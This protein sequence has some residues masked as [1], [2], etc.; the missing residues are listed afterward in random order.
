MQT[1]SDADQ[2][3]F[4]VFHLAKMV[5]K[6]EFVQDKQHGQ[7]IRFEKCAV[8][9]NTSCYALYDN[10]SRHGRDIS[11]ANRVYGANKSPW[12]V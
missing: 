12:L 6:N 4:C 2:L 1:F 8:P 10:D 11:D 7:L 5:P 3:V 9:M